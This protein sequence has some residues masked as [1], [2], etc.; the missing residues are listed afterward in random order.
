VAADG[1]ADMDTGSLDILFDLANS[2]PPAA[3]KRKTQTGRMALH[4]LRG[5]IFR[6]SW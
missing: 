3:P 5:G 2:I 1:L 6:S 4:I